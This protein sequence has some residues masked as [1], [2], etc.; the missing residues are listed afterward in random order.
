MD[1]FSS[2][3]SECEITSKG[4]R[5]VYDLKFPEIEGFINISDSS[6]LPDIHAGRHLTER[7]KVHRP[8]ELQYISLGS[9]DSVFRLIFNYE[10]RQ[11]KPSCVIFAK[12]QELF[13]VSVLI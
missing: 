11:K 3:Q 13:E 10:R 6:T 2:H 9:T 12:Y 1:E 5:E 7:L 4:F 8:T